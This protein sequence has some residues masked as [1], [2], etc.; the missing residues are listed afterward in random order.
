[1][2]R[3]SVLQA[4]ALHR[5][6]ANDVPGALADLD[7]ADQAAAEP[8]NPFYLRS[9]AINTNLI[10]AYALVQG[11]D[12]ASGEALAMATWAQRPYS[13]EVVGAALT[14]VGGEGER[15][16]LDRLMRTAGQIDPSLSGLIFRQE[17][18]TGRFEAALADY[19]EVVAPMQNGDRGVNVSRAEMIAHAEQQ[20]VRMELFLLSVIG[21][22]AYALA[23]LGRSEEARAA[24]AVVRA[25]IVQAT[26]PG[27][28]ANPGTIEYIRQAA[29]LRSNAEIE[30]RAPAIR[31]TWAELVEA[32][33]A[34]G[35]GR[36]EEAQAVLAGMDIPPSYAVV[37]LMVAARI[38]E[39]LIERARQTLPPTRLG[40]P[41][42]NAEMLFS[43][44]LDAETRERTAPERTLMDALLGVSVQGYCEEG[45]QGAGLVRVCY[46]G[47]DATLAV[48]QERALLLAAAQAARRGGR[49]RIEER[50]YIQHSSV[51]TM[52][53][54]VIG[55]ETQDGFES[56]LVIR[57][58]DADDV[59]ARCLSAADVQ[60]SLSNIYDQRS[61][62][63]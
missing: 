42:R 35:E 58:F 54:Q 61:A 14:I 49:F 38:D 36:L 22:K 9:L 13:R 55:A 6:I 7:L 52:Y 21:Q 26:L 39:P 32:R 28:S 44:L 46:N 19:R 47:F 23:A 10:R 17:F 4:R 15:A 59:C 51:S 18:E 16:N 5:L 43:S 2:R 31:D 25:R 27:G 41:E 62:R 37:D 40:L 60:S 11:G 50:D 63:Q 56:S 20:R 48:A 33:I 29:R 30:A 12:H 57:F 1:M 8:Q 3:V 34:A 53:G 24:L 45:P